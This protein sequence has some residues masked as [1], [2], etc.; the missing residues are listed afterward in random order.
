MTNS[1][2][3]PPRPP[4][5]FTTPDWRL[6]LLCNSPPPSASPPATH[7]LFPPR[8]RSV[9]KDPCCPTQQQVPSRT[10][11]YST[12]PLPPRLFWW[13]QSISGL[14]W[15]SFTL[16]RLFMNP[17]HGPALK[18]KGHTRRSVTFSLVSALAHIFSQIK[19]IT[20]PPF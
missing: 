8:R 12:P 15:F 18:P 17:D 10:P 9:R 5:H 13:N 7:V 1:R 4:S 19:P 2:A 16:L 11:V 14:M 3:P 20:I 6:P